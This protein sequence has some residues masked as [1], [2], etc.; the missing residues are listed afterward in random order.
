MHMRL[1]AGP[2]EKN[3]VP[4]YPEPMNTKE[5]LNLMPGRTTISRPADATSEGSASWRTD[6]AML[7]I[8]TFAVGTDA[9]V[10]AGV[11]P[12]VAST[13]HV[14]IAG[15]GQMVTVFSLA[16]ALSAPVVGAL[17]AGWPRRTSLSVGILVLVL[18]NILTALAP[19]FGLVLASRV[20]AAVGA[21][22]YTA[23]ASA[24]AAALAGPEKRGQAIAIV[25]LGMTSSLVLGAPLGTAISTFSNW[26]I[27]LYAVAALG[28]VAG[29]AVFLRI[30]P[31]RDHAAAGLAVR[32]SPLRDRQIL[33]ILLRALLVFTGIFIPYTYIS[34]IYAP[35]T[36]PHPQLLS[37]LVLLF[38]AAGTAGNLLAG[39][40]ADRL[41]PPRVLVAGSLGL[42]LIFVLIPWTRETV[43]LAL[44]CTFAAG[45]FTFSQT[46]PQQHLILSHAPPGTQSFVTGLYQAMLY[47]GVS[48]AGAFGALFLQHAGA[49]YLSLL[50]AIFVLAALLPRMSVKQ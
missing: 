2:Q 4:D 27:T 40:L 13:L 44:P 39:H 28:L 20:V 18:G 47:L 37:V 12:S 26:R 46:T 11:L 42:A 48:L 6:V 10:I 33:R 23:T 22:L 3:G 24:T 38:G 36:Q 17:C 30:P 5:P 15:A 31:L 41:G 7:A 49:H 19:G 29:V 21:G 8:G 9:F 34:A 45:L 14:S 35:L 1:L 25:I 43:A 16:Y 50:A 32:L